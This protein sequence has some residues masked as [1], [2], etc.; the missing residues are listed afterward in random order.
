MTLTIDE[1]VYLS[2]VA[3]EKFDHFTIGIDRKAIPLLVSKGLIVGTEKGE[4]F[5]RWEVT[6]KGRSFIK[7]VRKSFFKDFMKAQ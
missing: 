6:E 2:Q 1:L 4:N 5:Y 3:D 7:S